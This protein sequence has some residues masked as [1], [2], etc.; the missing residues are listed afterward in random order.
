MSDC[1]CLLCRMAPARPYSALRLELAR[2][3]SSQHGLLT[4]EQALSLGM[5]SSALSRRVSSG[6]WERVYPGVYR[7]VAAPVTQAQTLL[8]AVLWAGEGATVSH[9]SAL[10]LWGYT[11]H[12]DLLHLSME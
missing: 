8:A 12:V 2:V 10:S 3:A 4:R 6:Q 9:F 11:T 5:S 1:W 7:V